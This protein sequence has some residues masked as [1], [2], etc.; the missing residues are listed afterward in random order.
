VLLEVE[1]GPGGARPV[2]L[3]VGE[4]LDDHGKLRAG[5]A[6]DRT[7]AAN[8]GSTLNSRYGSHGCVVAM[9]IDARMLLEPADQAAYDRLDKQVEAAISRLGGPP[10]GLMVHFG[11][12]SRQ[13]FLI[14]E[15]GR[16]EDAFR[17]FSRD[18]IEPAIAAAGPAAGESEICPVWSLA[19][20]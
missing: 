9:A 11:Y 3:G 6:A 5:P 16:S 8:W 14:V 13:G 15:E 7:E 4:A 19:R 20:P 10:E 18:V 1:I 12:P 17:S 2:P